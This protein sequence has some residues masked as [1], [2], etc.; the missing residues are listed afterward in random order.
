M[1][2]GIKL[3]TI[4]LLTALNSHVN[5]QPWLKPLYLKNI[6][7]EGNNFY[8]IQKAFRAYEN[9]MERKESE[10]DE[11]EEEGTFQGH[12]QY[13]RW[14]WFNEQRVFPT[15]EFPT[16]EMVL[17]EYEKFKKPIHF[18]IHLHPTQTKQLAQTGLT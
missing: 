1:K 3:L 10:N 17:K 13:K 8:D 4:L 5:A 16:V 7:S 15:G 6:K 9:D 18:L 2:A 14:E 12:N 11:G